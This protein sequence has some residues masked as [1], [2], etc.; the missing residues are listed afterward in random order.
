MHGLNELDAWLECLTSDR[1]DA[2]SLERKGFFIHVVKRVQ[3]TCHASPF[4][5]SPVRRDGEEA[6][7]VSPARVVI[8]APLAGVFYRAVAPEALPFIAEG[9]W[10]R[11]GQMVGL[12]EAMKLMN[13]C[14]AEVA[15]RVAR[16]FAVDGMAVADGAP[17]IELIPDGAD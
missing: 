11:A 6:G 10:V 8:R 7:S 1:V 5:A 12:L 14:R 2:L 3:G 4:D 13:E 9:D 17:L 15:G 16:I